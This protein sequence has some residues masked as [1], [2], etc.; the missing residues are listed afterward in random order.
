MTTYAAQEMHLAAFIIAG[1]GRPGGWRYPQSEDGWL[2]LDYY[3]R[4]AETL[5]RGRFDLAFFADILAVPN[6]YQASMDSQLRYGALGSLR[7]EPLQVLATMAAATRHLG[8][9]ATKS[10]SYYEPF[11]VARGIATLDHLSAGRAAWNIVTSFQD[12]EARNFSRGAHI[13]RDRRYDRADE[14]LEV[15]HKLWD[16]WEDGALVADRQ[17][18]LFADPARVHPIGHEGEWFSVDGPLN[19][20][21][22]PQ[23]Y[24]VLI[25]AGA[26]ER[27]RD[28][29]ARWSDVI[30]VTHYS[31]DSAIAFSTE[32]K[33]RAELHGRNPKD[34]KILPGI[35]PLVGETEAIVRERKQ[36]L[37]ERIEPEAGLST[38]SYHLDVDLAAYPLDEPLPQLN[39]PGVTGHYDEMREA[40]D[41]GALPLREVGRMY[42]NRY[43]GDFVGTPEAVAD[44]MQE[45]HAAGACDGFMV[46]AHWQP[47]A[48]DDFVRLVVPELQRRGLFRKE[49]T[50]RTLRDHLGLARPP[51]GSWRTERKKAKAA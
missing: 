32:M 31:L 20:P 34:L 1:P 29:A 30:F 5:E 26:S 2:D 24:P 21:R 7:L 39:V 37:A 18:P 17:T 40:S 16:S 13:P 19:V 11:D 46:A 12:A 45:W 9:A 10:T 33:R 47:G 51:A 49:Y 43:E 4:I 44:R 28:F 36:V 25:Q 42:A 8:L 15:T 6:R 48:F 38:L 3:R 27:G 14:F 23:G 41:K 50:G 22:P 35:T